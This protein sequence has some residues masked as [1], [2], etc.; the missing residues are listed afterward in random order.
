MIIRDIN[1]ELGIL[2]ILDYYDDAYFGT[3]NNIQAIVILNDLP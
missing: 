3:S 1:M 2:G